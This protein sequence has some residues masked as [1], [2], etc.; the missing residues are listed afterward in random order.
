MWRILLVTISVGY[1]PPFYASVYVPTEEETLQWQEKI[2][3]ERRKED[4]PSSPFLQEESPLSPVFLKK[5]LP[6]SSFVGSSSEASEDFLKKELDKDEEDLQRERFSSVS[7]HSTFRPSQLEKDY[8][9]EK[10]DIEFFS[11]MKPL[12]E[13]KFFF[14]YVESKISYEYKSAVFSSTYKQSPAKNPVYLRAGGMNFFAHFLRSHLGIGGA[15]G[16]SY[17]QGKGLFVDG[18]RSSTLFTFW[19]FPVEVILAYELSLWDWGKISLQGGPGYALLWQN[20]SDFDERNSQKN[21]YQGSLGYYYSGEIQLDLFKIVSLS[22]AR[23]LYR[24]YKATRGFLTLGL[25]RQD[26]ENFKTSSLTFS[27]QQY[28]VGFAIEFL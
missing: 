22:M 5:N 11:Q 6:N 14:Q 1:F 25:R 18:Q 19:G 4:G 12:S 24:E 27:G 17:H 7:G 26:Y 2:E 3:K 20:R 16:A 8:P 21:L 13:S 23:E 9:G 28:F 10:E 15:A